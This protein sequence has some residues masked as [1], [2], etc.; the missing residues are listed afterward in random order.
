MIANFV[1]T[2]M[3]AIAVDDSGVC[4]HQTA[5]PEE[6]P[7]HEQKL[8]GDNTKLLHVQTL[9]DERNSLPDW[10]TIHA[11]WL[12]HDSLLTLDLHFFRFLFSVVENSEHNEL[13]TRHQTFY[14]CAP[15]TFQ[16]PRVPSDNTPCVNDLT[17]DPLSSNAI[18]FS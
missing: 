15:T 6:N 1:G 2:T 4:I 14:G 16:I 17:L 10:R 11:P 13:I 7:N 9:I 5:E 18:D 3:T 8:P 12:E